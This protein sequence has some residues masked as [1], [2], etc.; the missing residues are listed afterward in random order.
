MI[1][2]LTL[3]NVGF[4]EN[5]FAQSTNIPLKKPKADTLTPKEPLLQPAFKI[6]HW[7]D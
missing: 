3:Y 7:S 6:I 2:Y 1:Q 5:G 4:L